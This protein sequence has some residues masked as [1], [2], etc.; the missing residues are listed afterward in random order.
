LIERNIDWINITKNWWNSSLSS[1]LSRKRK[2]EINTL[3]KNSQFDE[4]LK[5]FKK[6]SHFNKT[7]ISFKKT[8][9]NDFWTKS[10]FCLLM[11]TR[12]LIT[13][14]FYLHLLSHVKWKIFVFFE[15]EK[16]KNS[17]WKTLIRFCYFTTQVFLCALWYRKS[18]NSIKSRINHDAISQFALNW[19]ERTIWIFWNKQL[20]KTNSFCHFIRSKL[21]KHDINVCY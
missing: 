17:F 20:R 9:S 13:K 19:L 2:K 12:F 15:E 3:R 10:L 11:R 16:D 21:W 18:A 8:K 7:T 14:V 1:Q 4:T 5:W 6:T